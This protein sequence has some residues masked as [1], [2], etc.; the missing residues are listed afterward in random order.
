[1]PVKS[2][3]P[4]NTTMFYPSRITVDVFNSVPF[5]ENWSSYSSLAEQ[6]AQITGCLSEHFV[7]EVQQSFQLSIHLC[8]AACPS[9]ECIQLV[10]PVHC[11]TWQCSVICHLSNDQLSCSLEAP[12]APIQELEPHHLRASDIPTAAR[13]EAILQHPHI[14]VLDAILEFHVY[15]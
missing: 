7:L 8:C 14:A 4:A 5:M 13:N 10:A 3:F 1:M 2:N 12:P 6:A 15:Q 9:A 11:W